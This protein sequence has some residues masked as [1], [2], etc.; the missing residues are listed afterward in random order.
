MASKRRKRLV[1]AGKRIDAIA[2]CGRLVAHLHIRLGP[3]H[4]ASL[5]R[6]LAHGVSYWV[7]ANGNGRILEGD[8]SF[9]PH[10]NSAKAILLRINALGRL[11][12]ETI[13]KTRVLTWATSR[14][15][16]DEC[17][18]R[19][20]L[21]NLFVERNRGLVVKLAAR[22]G[23]QSDEAIS[24]AQEGLAVAM[25]TF[26]PF[27]N[28]QF[29]TWA[30]PIISHSLNSAYKKGL[31]LTRPIPHYCVAIREPTGPDEIAE[32]DEEARRLNAALRTLPGHLVADAMTP[33]TRSRERTARQAGAREIIKNLVF[34]GKIM[35]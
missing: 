7:G 23:M 19:D 29:S 26:N 2:A 8:E 27:G 31:K 28:V 18:E 6:Y 14:R 20:T 5:D 9:T 16:A 1:L 25:D 21:R 24:V 34:S 22:T 4:R 33:P 3:L 15:L 11:I 35:G 12:G 30:Y 32:E 17:L 13:T 10:G